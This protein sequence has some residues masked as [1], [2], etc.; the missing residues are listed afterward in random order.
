MG[1]RKASDGKRK[2]KVRVKAKGRSLSS[3]RWLTRQ[4]NNVQ[5]VKSVEAGAS[6]QGDWITREGFHKERRGARFIGVDVRDHAFGEAARKSRLEEV[7][8]RLYDLNQQVLDW[9]GE[10][11]SELDRIVE[12]EPVL[13]RISAAK[14]LRDA[15]EREARRS[16]C[17]KVTAEILTKARSSL[18]EGQA[19]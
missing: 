16:G 2:L 19:A 3:Q 13:V 4:L 9:E 15:A 17:T 8:R 10:A 14:R 11:K 5:R 6:V 7:S 18:M 12:R 1:S